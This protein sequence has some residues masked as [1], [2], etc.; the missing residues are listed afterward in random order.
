MGRI[1]G[2]DL[3]TTNSVVS[4]L[5]NGEAVVLPNREG[6]RITPSMVGF[7]ENGEPFVGHQAKRQAILNPE[8]TVFGTKR[9]MGRRFDDPII[10]NLMPRLPFT[11]VE[12]KNG[13]AWVS[14]AGKNLSPQEVSAHILG[15][16]KS[17][18]EDYFGE[19]V[20]Q[21][22]IT[23]PANFDDAQRQATKEAGRLAGLEV[24]RIVNEP[25]A[26]ALA[27][28]LNKREEA[29]VG[30]FDLGGG[31]FDISILRLKH[32]VFEV[33]STCGDNTLGG[34]DFDQT[35]LQALIDKF[36][37]EAGIDITGDKMAIQRL[38]EAAEAAKCELSTISE[39]NINLPFLAVGSSGPKHFNTTLSRSKLNDLVY[40]LVQ[41]LHEPCRQALQ[42]AGLRR[43]ELDEVLLVGG[44]TRMP[45][46]REQVQQIFDVSLQ[47]SVNPDEVVAMGAAIQSGIIGGEVREVVLLDVTPI[48]LGIRVVGNRFSRIIP[49]NTPIP[50][51]ETKVFTT[52][53]NNQDLV[54]I[55]VLQG[56][57][58]L[59][60]RNKPL[61]TFNLT[62]IPQAAAG[63]PRIE[64]AFDIDT[65]GILNVSAQDMKTKKSQSI[66]ITNAHGLSSEEFYTAKDRVQATVY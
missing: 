54:S 30:V 57:N 16:L 36:Y 42:D 44:M 59:A 28:G 13:D 49:R 23:V 2:I 66:V 27:Y 22:V 10:Q 32:G 31:T 63:T 46:V 14:V 53:E 39:T 60:D 9:L 4:A 25:T 8:R 62:G 40:G 26:A 56:E 1:I 29:V 19:E 48:S 47:R 41:R 12:N 21:A 45:L 7:A 18:A 43:N 34:D 15:K 51:R 5:E 3:G 55:T 37:Q 17:T 61:G 11:I 33:L 64:V 52:T 24:L 6:S 20:A 38:R 58:E 65:D 35:I 50:A